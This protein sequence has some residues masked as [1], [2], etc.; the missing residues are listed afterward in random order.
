[1]YEMKIKILKMKFIFFNQL[2]EITSNSK[3]EGIT[4]IMAAKPVNM[5]CVLGRVK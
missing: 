3:N 4:V 2:L 5:R 1:M